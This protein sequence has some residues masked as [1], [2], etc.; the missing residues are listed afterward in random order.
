MVEDIDLYNRSHQL[1]RR[2]LMP[3]DWCVNDAIESGL[4]SSIEGAAGSSAPGI[5]SQ[6]LAAGKYAMWNMQPLLG[7]LNCGKYLPLRLSGGMQLELTLADAADAVVAG[8]STSYEIQEMSLRCAVSKLDS[9]LESSFAQ[10]M[11]QNRALTLR[12]NT[13]RFRA[14]QRA[15]PRC[16]FRSYV[17]SRA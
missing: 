2:I 5:A 9:A 12:L 1:Y 3:N 8:S 15:T 11:M 14:Y 7:I 17:R 10:M 6:Q 13:Y 16:P 4:Q